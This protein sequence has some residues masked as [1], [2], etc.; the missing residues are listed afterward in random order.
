MQARLE[1]FID[2]TEDNHFPLENIPFGVF[3]SSHGTHCCTR[4][5][6]Q[7]IDLASIFDK[8]TGPHFAALN[9]DNIFNQPNL[10]KFASLGKDIRI[11]ARE[12]L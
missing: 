7:V 10:N 4:I 11:E 3:K 8:F 9:G 1:S 5:G 6:D 2:Y 12:T